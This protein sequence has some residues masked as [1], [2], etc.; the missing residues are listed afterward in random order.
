MVAKLRDLAA[1][2]ALLFNFKAVFIGHP[3][4]KTDLSAMDVRVV[5]VWSSVVLEAKS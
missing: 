4:K 5:E 3:T 1:V 2:K